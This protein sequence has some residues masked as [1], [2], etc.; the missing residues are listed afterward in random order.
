[1]TNRNK[2]IFSTAA[3]LAL[4][5]GSVGTAFA[6]HGT[7]VGPITGTVIQKNYHENGTVNGFVVG[8]RMLTF[9]AV[10]SGIGSLDVSGSVTYSGTS[11]TNAD[12]TLS[13]VSV[14][15]F[16]PTTGTYTPVSSTSTEYTSTAGTLGAFNYDS[17]GE[18]NGFFWNSTAPVAGTVLVTIDAEAIAKLGLTPSTVTSVTGSTRTSS[19]GAAALI[20]IAPSAL[21]GV[22]VRSGDHH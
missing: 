2:V 22:A 1:M 5:A 6:G 18:V 8:T 10:C 3:V 11:R 15:S 12:A 21:N 7:T 16:T 4:L 17:S 14:T 20:V 13:I 9:P 19:C